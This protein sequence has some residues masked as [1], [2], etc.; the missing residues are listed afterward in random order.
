MKD[1]KGSRNYS[2]TTLKVLFAFSGNQCAH[3]DCSE[4]IVASQTKYSDAKVIGHIA[5]IYAHSDGGPR[6]KPDLTEA[7]RISPSNL[8]LLCPT[9]HGH[10][11]GQHETYPAT[12]LLD[13]KAKHERKYQNSLR[14]SITDL[15]YAELEVAA[16][17]LMASD[18]VE[19]DGNT[20]TL[21][22][23]QKI[24]KNNLGVGTE[25][26]LKMG[27]AKSE[28]V[29]A[30]LQKSAQLD[31]GFPDRL[32]EGFVNRYNKLVSEGLKGDDLFLEMWT[33]AGGAG[34]DKIREAAGLCILTHLFIICDVFEK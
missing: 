1:G 15:G 4:P 6:S 17:A 31:A 11:D 3:P 12:L 24:E 9:H 16:R 23:K 19:P 28:E 20:H 14:V 21:P 27:A 29:Q 7:E 32:R 5:H 30:T 34:G 2:K 22:P 8:L 26:L 10:V 33:W 13:W 18:S 25:S